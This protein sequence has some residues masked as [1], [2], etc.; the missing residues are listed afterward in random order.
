[1]FSK[2]VSAKGFMVEAPGFS[3]VSSKRPTSG[4]LGCLQPGEIAAKKWALESA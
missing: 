2:D 3:G 4:L 1:V